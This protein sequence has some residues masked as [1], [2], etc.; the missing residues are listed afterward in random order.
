MEIKTRKLERA[1][2]ESADACWLDVLTEPIL[3]ALTRL[4]QSV[5]AQSLGSAKIAERCH[6]GSS[7]RGSPHVRLLRT[8]PR[9]R[10]RRRCRQEGRHPRV[11]CYGPHGSGDP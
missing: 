2:P 1:D 6:L 10:T 11:I 8:L 7:R 9:H 3:A 4:P 5:V